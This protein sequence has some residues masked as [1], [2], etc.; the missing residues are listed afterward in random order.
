MSRLDN[1]KGKSY[2]LTLEDRRKGGK[3]SSEKKRLANGLKNLK[4]GKNS[5]N[6]ILLLRCSDCPYIFNCARKTDGYCSYLLDDLRNDRQFFR[7]VNKHL[8][9][10][11][12]H[13]NVAFIVREIYRLRDIFLEMLEDKDIHE[14]SDS[15]G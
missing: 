11:K 12:D 5:S 7:L 2:T 3:I 9:Y 8:R 6:H 14:S 10:G 15:K 1:F 13:E 4:H